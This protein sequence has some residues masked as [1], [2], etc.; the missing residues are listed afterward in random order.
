MG[1]IISYFFPDGGQ[2]IS[3]LEANLV[4]GSRIDQNGDGII[5]KEEL[6]MWMV[7]QKEELNRFK[8]Q[9]EESVRVKYEDE[10][11][12]AKLEINSLK[13]EIKVLE[14]L[15]LSLKNEETDENTVSKI[16]KQL[17]KIRIKH[18]VDEMLK[19]ENVNIKFFPDWVERKIYINMFTLLL[20]ALSRATDSTSLKILDHELTF[21]F[22][23]S[24][25]QRD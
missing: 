2:E 5:T 19:D 4:D 16:N 10:L 8:Q 25:N 3:Q 20:N 14:Q 6:D 22:K 12:S 13:E 9:I 1:S 11:N 24:S 15:N 23:P 7:K 18:M 17:S 21:D